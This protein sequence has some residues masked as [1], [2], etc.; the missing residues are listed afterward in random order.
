MRTGWIGLALLSVAT[1]AIA[2][3]GTGAQ[4]GVFGGSA[5]RFIPTAIWQRLLERP[6]N[7]PDALTLPVSKA[8]AWAAVEAAFKEFDLPVTVTDSAAGEIATVGAKM[9]KRIGKKP[10]SDFLRCGDG[11]AGPNADMYVVYVSALGVVKPNGKTDQT[12]GIRLTGQAVDLPNGRSDVVDCTSSGVFETL[13]TKR[14]AKQ[15]T[16]PA[17][18]KP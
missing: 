15:L 6:E 8:A 2:Q 16:V 17:T 9:Y 10:I 18:S 7:A 14:V 4:G 5:P 12:I 11:A 3:Q 1:P 13:F